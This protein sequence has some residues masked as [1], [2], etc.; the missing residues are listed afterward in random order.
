[1]LNKLMKNIFM[2]LH[3]AKIKIFDYQY[4]PFFNYKNFI[5]I[6]DY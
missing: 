4:E 1:M 2:N 6:L 5:K 3:E